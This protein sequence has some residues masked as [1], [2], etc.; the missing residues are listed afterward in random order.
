MRIG[1]L[2]GLPQPRDDSL[3]L[4]L[5]VRQDGITRL[6]LPDPERSL[7]VVTGSEASSSSH[8]GAAFLAG[9]LPGLGLE[10][11]STLCN[12][13]H[14]LAMLDSPRGILYQL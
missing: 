10:S 5:D 12:A 11:C 9:R 14:E 1:R 6:P 2:K 4:A 8:D 7:E 3:L 13:L